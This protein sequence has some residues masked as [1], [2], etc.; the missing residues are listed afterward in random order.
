M[1]EREHTRQPVEET[2]PAEAAGV[3]AEEDLEQTD[4]GVQDVDMDPEDH[5]NR[6]DQPDYDPAER[7]PFDDPDL[8]LPTEDGA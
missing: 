8:T 1:A 4:V 6:P 2:R 7:R 5:V 3:P